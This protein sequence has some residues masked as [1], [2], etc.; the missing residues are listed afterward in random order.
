MK[1]KTFERLFKEITKRISKTVMV[2]NKDYSSTSDDRLNNFKRGAEMLRCTPERVLIGYW[3][4]HAISI[5][6][7]VDRIDSGNYGGLTKE[8]LEEKIGDGMV[9]LALLEGIIKERYGWL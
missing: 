1:S 7:I 2:K 4:K 3:T 8:Q 6:D 9:Y 5:L